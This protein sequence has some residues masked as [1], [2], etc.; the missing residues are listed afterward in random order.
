MPR[1]LRPSLRASNFL[2]RSQRMTRLQQQARSRRLA[3]S[4]V[5]AAD[6]PALPQSARAAGPAA[7][8][9]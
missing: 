2:A 8:A 7:A 6:G 3:F 5:L 4:G 9:T 1:T